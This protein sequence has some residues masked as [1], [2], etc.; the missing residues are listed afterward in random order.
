MSQDPSPLTKTISGRSVMS[1]RLAKSN[2]C[3]DMVE[4]TIHHLHEALRIGGRA[5]AELSIES[6]SVAGEECPATQPLQLGMRHDGG[7]EALP[8]PVAAG[9]LESE[10]IA[11]VGE[12]GAVADHAGEADLAAVLEGAEAERVLDGAGDRLARHAL[13]PVRR[14]EKAGDHDLRGSV[15]AHAPPPPA[16]RSRARPRR[17]ASARAAPSLGVATNTVS[18]PAMV[19]TT[20]ASSAS[21]R[22]RA[23][24]CAVAGGVFTITSEPAGRTDRAAFRR[25]RRSF[26]SR[27]A[28][29]AKRATGASGAR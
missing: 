2:A 12:S 24:G 27:S 20:L 1:M 15:L 9:R 23:T 16:R 22:A 26:S 21:S 19:P 8:H 18:S 6:M 3:S 28:A 11:D 14:G 13:R 4:I 25:V 10:H 7:H 29:G 5:E 17:R